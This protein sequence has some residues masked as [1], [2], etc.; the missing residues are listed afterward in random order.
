[1]GLFDKLKATAKEVA[2]QAL[3][4]V[5][6]TTPNASSQ[7]A[8]SG[9]SAT[10]AAEPIVVEKPQI[11]YSQMVDV[12]LNQ[13][14]DGEY[15][16]VKFVGF[17]EE[18]MEIP[19][20]IN[21]QRI[22]GIADEVF[23]QL[24]TLTNLKISEGIRYIGSKTFSEC[25]DLEVVELPESLEKI[26]AYC[27]AETKILNIKIPSSVVEIGEGAFYECKELQ[28]AVLPEQLE[29]IP[30]NMFCRCEIL[31]EITFPINLSVVGANAFN[32]AGLIL[33][34]LP[35]T[36]TTIGDNGFAG[37][38]QDEDGGYDAVEE[39]RLPSGLKT[40]GAEGLAGLNCLKLIIPASVKSIGE[41]AFAWLG[42][43][44]GE[45]EV[46][47]EDGCSAELPEGLFFNGTLDSDSTITSMTIPSTITVINDIFRG[48][49][50]ESYYEH[51]KDEYGRQVYDE[52]GEAIVKWHYK[53][54]ICD[55]APENLTIYCDPGSAAMKF[56]R[57]KGINCAKRE[58]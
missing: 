35:E 4:S 12:E 45:I 9:A 52:R 26:G 37:C 51:V 50:Q 8:T 30:A 53:D 42:C 20:E 28:S 56:A 5:V 13:V 15:E 55:D 17:E 36:I 7:D 29:E 19:A 47:F 2:K 44:E 25:P 38:F 6:T 1:M 21:G 22:V 10:T 48:V 31:E 14:A 41:K 32:N 18:N 34:S 54:V 39:F 40:I 58:N 11:E 24:V 23:F 27:F 57:E 49:D 33:E 43:V 16:I 46:V 3:E